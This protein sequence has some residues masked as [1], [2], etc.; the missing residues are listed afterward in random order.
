MRIARLMAVAPFF[1]AVAQAV[2]PET[3]SVLVSYPN[4]TPDYILSSAKDAVRAAGGIITHEYSLIKAFAARA[5]TEVFDTV[6]ALNP[7]YE[8][9]IEDDQIV[10][11]VRKG[12]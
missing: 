11:A 1:A 10:T 3:K 5:S 9:L 7:E 6:K 2:P 8:A 12:S 4:D